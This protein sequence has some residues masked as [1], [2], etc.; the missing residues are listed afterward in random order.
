MDINKERHLKIYMEKE[1]SLTIIVVFAI[2][3]W[4]WIYSENDAITENFTPFVIDEELIEGSNLDLTT[5][6]DN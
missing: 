2:A 5:L 6:L 4:I 1:Y 3:V